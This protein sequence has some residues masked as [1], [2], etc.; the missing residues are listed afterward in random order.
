MTVR[1]KVE[2]RRV[3]GRWA[4]VRGVSGEKGLG[5][6][7]ED[8]EGKGESMRRGVTVRDGRR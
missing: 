6:G 3:E 7:S 2:A 5:N 4:A 1:G 8:C